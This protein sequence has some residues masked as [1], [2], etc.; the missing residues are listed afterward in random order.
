MNK[1]SDIFSPFTTMLFKTLSVLA[2]AVGASATP[3]AAPTPDP[4][5]APTPAPTKEKKG[6][7]MMKMVR[8]R[9]LKKISGEEDKDFRS[10]AT[11][12][13]RSIRVARVCYVLLIDV[14]SY[15]AFAIQ[16]LHM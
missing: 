1:L 14:V 10:L 11:A 16:N 15:V 13:R 4:T 2:L 7:G 6:G 9:L 3:T 5:P 12:A 8:S